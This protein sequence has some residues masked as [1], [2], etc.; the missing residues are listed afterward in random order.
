M[1]PPGRK[2]TA[3]PKEKTNPS[4]GFL[5]ASLQKLYAVLVGQGARQG[6]LAAFDQAQ[7]SLANFLATLLLARNASPT[8]LGIY[9]VGFTALRLVRAIQEGVTIQPLNTY[10]AGMDQ[11]TFNSYATSTS[12][13]QIALALGCAAAAAA[14]GW[15]LIQLGNDVSGLALFSL[16]SGFLW[17]QLQEYLR[18]MLY[19]RGLVREALLNSFL[20]NVIRLALM[21]WLVQSGSLDGSASL[22]AIAVGSAGALVL[23]LWQTRRFWT[24]RIENL[25][26]TWKRNWD[27]GRWI[28]GGLVANWVAV[29]FYPVLTAGMISFAAAGAYRALQNVVAPVHMLLRAVDTFLTPRAAR[30]F[31]E[32]SYPAMQHMIRITFILCSVPVLGLLAVAVLFPSQLLYFLY[33]DTY[34]AYSQGM[35][36]MALFYALLFIYWPP[37]TA[38]KAIRFSR[39]IFIANQAAILAMFTAGIW[40]I[41][42]WGLY[43]TIGGQVLN[44]LIIC[45]ILWAA[46]HKKRREYH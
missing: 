7:I 30:A 31:Q 5:P 16:W 29:E 23:G 26:G 22:H 13:I 27:F 38:F 19:T 39:P 9:G 32:R 34:L 15:L 10:G 1:A 3:I 4:P 2:I 8:E 12:L 46:W 14:G 36:L 40:M 17:W 11:E 25:L 28:T 6:Y 33:G 35:A 21:L 43:G 44:S 24:T 37:Q 20:S 42:Q 18:R 41:R 45:V